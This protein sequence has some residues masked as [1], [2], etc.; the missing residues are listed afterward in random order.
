MA[1]DQSFVGRTYPP[2]APYE[3]GREK[4]REFA[5]AVGDS[6]PAYVDPAA[7]RELGHSDVIAPPPLSSRSLSRLRGRWCR[8]RSWVWTTAVWC[9]VTRSSRMCVRCGR[10]TG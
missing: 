6:N 3:V 7:A 9:T 10:G 1:L 5:E 2:T 8:T 4:I